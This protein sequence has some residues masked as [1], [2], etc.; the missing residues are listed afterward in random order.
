MNRSEKVTRLLTVTGLIALTGSGFQVL[1]PLDANASS[2][3]GC[4][5]CTPDGCRL[6]SNEMVQIDYY[7]SFNACVDYDHDNKGHCATVS[8][9]N[10]K[11]FSYHTTPGGNVVI[12]NN[13]GNYYRVD[14]QHGEPLP[15]N[16]CSRFW[17]API[18]HHSE[19][20]L[21]TDQPSV[22]TRGCPANG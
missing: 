22:V 12:D 5:K 6:E 20:D 7:D 21:D 1:R 3:R 14:C 13:N 18:L 15:S 19:L 11:I 2:Y 17:T 9:V 10:Y 16:P 4:G 8:R